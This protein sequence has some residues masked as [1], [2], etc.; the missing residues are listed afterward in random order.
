[1]QLFEYIFAIY[2]ILQLL[3]S[4]FILPFFIKPF[5]HI[6]KKSGQKFKHLTKEKSFRGFHHFEKSFSCQKLFQNREWTFKST[7]V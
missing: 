3:V 4:N 6:T 1:M 7:E 2:S 5:S